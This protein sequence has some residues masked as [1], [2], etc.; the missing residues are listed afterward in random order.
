MDHLHIPEGCKP[1]VREIPYLGLA[2]KYDGLGF[3]GFP[4]RHGQNPDK[5]I[6]LGCNP[7]QPAERIQTFF[8]RQRKESFL[9]EWLWFGLMDEFS[10]GCNL[11]I[12][13]DDFI[14][15]SPSGMGKIVSTAPLYDVYARR[16]AVRALDA[17][18][19]TLGLEMGDLVRLPYTASELVEDSSGPILDLCVR[20]MEQRTSTPLEVKVAQAVEKL[21]KPHGEDTLT[22]DENGITVPLDTL[23]HRILQSSALFST[24]SKTP[25]PPPQLHPN[26]K[27]LAESIARVQGV[28]RVIMEQSDPILRFDVIV[29][30]DVLCHTLANIIEVLLDEPINLHSPTFVQSFEKIMCARN[31]CPSRV[32]NLA[33][34]DNTPLA[35]I[36]SLLPSYETTLHSDCH[37]R[38]CLKLPSSTEAMVRAHRPG[39]NQK[40]LPSTVPETKLI[41]MWNTGGIPGVCLAHGTQNHS[42]RV[43]DCTGQSFIAISHVW[44]HGLGNPQE[45]NEIPSCQLQYLCELVNL[46]GGEETTLWLDTLSIPAKDKAARRLAISNMRKIYSEASKVLVIDKDLLQ[47]GSDRM[48]QMMQLL[49][50]EWQRRLWTLQE[51]RLARDLFIQFKEG[52]VAAS[53]LMA[54]RPLSQFKGSNS[55]VFS[56]AFMLKEDMQLRFSRIEVGESA[57][58]T[59]A[60]DLAA[61]STTYKTDEPICLA[62]LLGVSLENYDPYPTMEDIYKAIPTIPQDLIFLNQERLTVP[63]LTWAPSTFLETEFVS[64]MRGSRQ[65]PP[66][67]LTAEGLIVTKDCLL[68][69]D[70]LDFRRVA[71]NPPEI[72]IV[73]TPQGQEFAVSAYNTVSAEGRSLHIE[74]SRTIRSPAVIWEKPFDFFTVAGVRS[75][76]SKAVLVSRNFERDGVIYCKF[77]M[78]LHGWHIR[79]EYQGFHQKMV[80]ESG[81]IFGRVM[82]ELENEKSFCV[83]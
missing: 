44:A 4:E 77:E 8:L 22:H 15:D 2:P 83:G 50:S 79:D 5:L 7:R 82:A 32:S 31:W 14:I 45:K 11:I 64:F 63:G 74:S 20:K 70:D 66:G 29:S 23:R 68:L 81:G 28:L 18:A 39:C 76:T 73:T 3:D 54:H 55:E 65:P 78:G 6:V 51:G 48:E 21:S 62:T 26:R 72:Y 35:Y 58:T 9:Q 80:R 60:E 12:N 47:V 27:K 37:P 49:G 40:C 24:L 16:L 75:R 69:G 67:R 56:F 38:K 17:N 71:T 33:N 34:A 61:R 10:K 52:P 36:A 13:L 43:V 46:L 25:R 59:L 53:E 41:N 1:N 19:L 42:V 57:L 30:I